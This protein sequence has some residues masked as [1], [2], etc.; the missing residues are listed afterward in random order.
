MDNVN[1]DP[2]AAFA[3]PRTGQA[4]T[5]TQR[6]SKAQPAEPIPPAVNAAFVADMAFERALSAA[7]GLAQHTDTTTEARRAVWGRPSEPLAA[8]VALP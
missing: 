1:F 8:A 3:N 4:A 2:N 7:R 6:P 5:A